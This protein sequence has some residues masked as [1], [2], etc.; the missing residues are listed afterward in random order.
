MA[1]YL[2]QI[3][4]AKTEVTRLK[5]EKEAF[6]QSNEP[7]DADE[8]ELKN[9]NYAKDLERQIRE[10]KA[11]NRDALRELAKAEKAAAKQK[12][13]EADRRAACAA[14]AAL[15]AVLDQIAVLE[16]TLA[17][18]EKIK[19]A[20]TAARARFRK[21]T[22]AFVSELKNRCGFMG[23]DKK[24]AIILELLARDVQ[25]GLDAS[26]SEKRQVLVRFVEE[27]WDKYCVTLMRL[28]CHRLETERQL[29]VL[30]KDLRYE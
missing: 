11:E 12:A 15:Q 20:L 27:L 16:S 3:A 6:E 24:R 26:V 29:D 19:T 5:G 8:E 4:A 18:Y 23:E 9:W 25:N 17:P 21:L 1:D 22:D 13:T 2:E 14:K 28:R 7:E 10:L 30:L